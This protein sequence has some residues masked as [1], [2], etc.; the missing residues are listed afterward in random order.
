M[1]RKPSY[2]A[3]VFFPY[4]LVMLLQL[5]AQ[6]F[7]LALLYQLTKPALLPLLILP[8]VLLVRSRERAFFLAL[9][10]LFFSWLGDLALMV[11]GELW[12]MVGLGM[13]LLAHIFYIWLFVKYLAVNRPH[14]LSSLYLIW[15]AALLY[16]LYPVLGGM[17]IPV[18]IY[19]LVL[20]AMGFFATRGNVFILLG[21]LLFVCSDSLLALNK[22]LPTEV[23]HLEHNGFWVML[24]YCL[25]QVCIAYGVSRELNKTSVQK[26]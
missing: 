5:I 8:L 13:F 11:P 21:G 2:V 10:G 17:F 7:D 6:W 23:Y 22:F 16:L 25:A 19:G 18:A 26:S 24:S 9:L 12:F 20:G 4:F 14:S 1:T 3:L 15:Y